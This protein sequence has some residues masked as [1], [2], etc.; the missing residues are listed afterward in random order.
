MLGHPE[1]TLRQQVW[2]ELAISLAA[3]AAQHSNVGVAHTVD[4]V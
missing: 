1:Q 4:M 2:Q 3:P